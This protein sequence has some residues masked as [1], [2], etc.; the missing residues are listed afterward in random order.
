MDNKKNTKKDIGMMEVENEIK[1]MKKTEIIN[2]LKE[3]NNK[4]KALET[5]GKPM[6]NN[7]MNTTNNN[8]ISIN[9]FLKEYCK[10]AM[11]LTDFVKGLTLSLEDLDY[12]G[13]HG[14]VKGMANILIK[15]LDHMEAT[16]RPIHCTDKKRLQFYVKDE[17]KWEKDDGNKKMD[18]SMDDVTS[19]QYS[20]IKDWQ[21]D[22]KGYEESGEK[23]QTFF[24][25][26]KNCNPS[27]D[28]DK[29]KVMKSMAESVQI[30]DAISKIKN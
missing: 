12:T 15:N 13:K 29:K 26:A 1:N 20:T 27:E 8:N 9:I 17:N 4:I 7:T 3:K 10:D 30:R 23:L 19:K 22:N 5:T 24:K 25:I 11:N 16:S 2:L 21:E 6:I 28:E 14:Y 18:K